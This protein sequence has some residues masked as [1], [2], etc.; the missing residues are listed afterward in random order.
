MNVYSL[1]SD[2][3]FLFIYK[4]RPYIYHPHCL[5]YVL[6]TELALLCLWGS[7]S[8]MLDP[9]Y[10]AKELKYLRCK[11]Y[12]KVMCGNLLLKLYSILILLC[13]WFKW[14]YVVNVPI[15]A[16]SVC[17]SSYIELSIWFSVLGIICWISIL[18]LHET[19]VVLK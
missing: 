16:S 11:F 15:C 13:Y 2:K 10:P 6:Y 18:S 7:I 14:Q 9:S 3:N 8:L 12:S 19:I 4:S 5:T 17:M 1:W